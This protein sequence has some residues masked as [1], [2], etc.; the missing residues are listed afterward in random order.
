MSGASRRAETSDE[1]N[2]DLRQQR[3]GGGLS[4]PGQ[5]GEG[6][7]EGVRDVN[8]SDITEKIRILTRMNTF[9]CSV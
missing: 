2:Q 5:P 7:R 1:S 3:R 8:S 9:T 4:S 6:L